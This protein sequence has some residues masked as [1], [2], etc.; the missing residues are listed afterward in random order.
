VSA[1]SGIDL[2]FVRRTPHRGVCQQGCFSIAA[3]VPH[4]RGGACCERSS[5]AD[6]AGGLARAAGGRGAPYWVAIISALLLGRLLPKTLFFT[7]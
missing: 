4:L 7:S 2:A 1:A 5:Q 6:I 3:S